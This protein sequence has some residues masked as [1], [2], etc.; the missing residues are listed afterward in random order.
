MGAAWRA[1]AVIP[2][3]RTAETK[4]LVSTVNQAGE[5]PRRIN[6]GQLEQALG[7]TSQD[8]EAV[9]PAQ[10][11]AML[12]GLA[13]LSQVIGSRSG[14]LAQL[15]QNVKTLSGTLATHGSELV[16]LLGQ[17]DLVLQV[18]NQRHTDIDQLLTT[19][20][21]LSTQLNALFAAHQAQIGPLLT[22]LQTVSAVLA[23]DGT[24]LATA[25]PLL[26]SANQYLANVTGSGA[27][28][29]FVLPTALIPDNVIAECLKPGA[30]KPLTG[31]NP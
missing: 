21:S 19:T 6:L 27:F 9:P 25:V 16:N 30:V 18:L 8:L 10:T 14:Q 3:S 4:T 7:V 26:A 28:G 29:D 23:K 22:D 15:V 12:Q 2:Q 5:R 17:A 24:D 13:Q 11:S 31:C 20:A 1:G